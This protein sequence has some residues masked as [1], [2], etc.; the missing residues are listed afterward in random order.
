MGQ[1]SCCLIFFLAFFTVVAS[2]QDFKATDS[3]TYKLYLSGDWKELINTGNEAIKSG[4]D[5]K[6]LR[7]RLGVAYF[8][9]GNYH[10]AASQFSK[11]LKFDSYDQFTLEYLYYT[12][13]NTGKEA[14]AGSLEKIMS[15]DLKQRLK[16]MSS[17]VL[18][19]IETEF[20]YKISETQLRSN[21]QFYRLGITSK[22]ASR[23]ELF[24]SFSYFGQSLVYQET[25]Y[26]RVFRLKQ[27]EY[28]VSLGWNASRSLI[29]RLSYHF[30]NTK[31]GATGFH[32][33][34]FRVDVIPDFKR[35]IFETNASYY[36]SALYNQYQ[37][38]VT[39]GYIFPGR[40]DFYL[41]ASA[42]VISRDGRSSFV[43][44]PVAGLRLW[45]GA[46]LEQTTTFGKMDGY[47]DYNGLYVY[48]NYDPVIL[49]SG[50]NFTWYLGRKA[51]LWVSFAWEKKEYY[52]DNSFL[53]H[54]FSY[55][56]GI[57]WK[58]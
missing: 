20:S 44:N 1:K 25:D 19:S 26:N 38:G 53:Y 36:N 52:E 31:N 14:Y 48:N 28:Y 15:P 10:D 43:Y 22:P 40:S 7:Q 21:S 13:L 8:S 46:W 42:S 32:G 33:N 29:M 57:K 11:A 50:A 51:T 18:E 45:K 16:I 5:Y 34:L 24:Q 27:P 54:Q 47:N 17:G 12:Y 3:I 55:L 35:Y 23:L 41:K 49:R 30:L 2:A 39:G 6:Y 37:L 4:I 56:G 58:I 9:L